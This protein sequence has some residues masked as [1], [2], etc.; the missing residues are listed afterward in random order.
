MQ[1]RNAERPWASIY[2]PY[3]TLGLQLA[4]SVVALFFVGRWLDDRW[5]TAPWLM[6]AGLLLGAVG[7]FVNFFRTVIALGKREDKEQRDEKD[8]THET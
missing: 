3:L 7:G 5:G 1:R 6:L 2:G 8:G 4:I